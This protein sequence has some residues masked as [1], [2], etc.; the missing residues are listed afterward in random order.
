MKV[1]GRHQVISTCSKIYV[2]VAT[3]NGNFPSV[4]IEQAT[5]TIGNGLGCLGIPKRSFWPTT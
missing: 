2:D 1:L 3:S 5:L 4:C